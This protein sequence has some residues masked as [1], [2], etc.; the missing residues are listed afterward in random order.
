MA[1]ENAKI[2]LLIG[3]DLLRVHKVRGQINGPHD[4]AFAQKR[5]LGSVII[6]DVCLGNT[7]RPSQVFSMKTYVFESG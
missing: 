4:A 2:L 5:D 7:H 1:Y 6:G 3:R